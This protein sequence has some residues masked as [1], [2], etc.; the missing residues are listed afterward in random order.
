MKAR[1]CGGEHRAPQKSKQTAAATI[2]RFALAVLFH[3][4]ET[5]LTHITGN[6]YYKHILR[7]RCAPSEIRHRNSRRVYEQKKEEEIYKQI[8]FFALYD[9]WV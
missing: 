8:Y 1:W 2:A 9:S 6:V 3:I 7:W 4:F 5:N